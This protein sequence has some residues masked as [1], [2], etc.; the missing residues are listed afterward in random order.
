MTDKKQYT[1]MNGLTGAFIGGLAGGVTMLLL[2]P[3]SGV[4]TRTRLQERSIELLDN[5]LSRIETVVSQMRS[6][7]IRGYDKLH[8]FSEQSEESEQNETEVV[9]QT[10]FFANAVQ[11]ENQ[12]TE[13]ENIELASPNDAE[14]P[15]DD[16]DNLVEQQPIADNVVNDSMGG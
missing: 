1:M 13:T 4:N 9:P 2:A 3:Q 15:M 12:S 10:N 14:R 5:A 11:T 6:G 16:I 8:D 7:L